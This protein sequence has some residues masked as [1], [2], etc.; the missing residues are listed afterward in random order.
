MVIKLMKLMKLIEINQREL[1]ELRLKQLKKQKYI[2]PICKRNIVKPVLDH[3]H[4]KRIKGTGLCRG[5]LCATCNV[6][7]GKI[8]NN[9]IR[10]CIS[11]DILPFVL[12]NLADYIENP[13][14]E[15]KYIHPSERTFKKLGKR[16]YNKI[17][18][19]YFNIFPNRKKVPK[20]PRSGKLTKQFEELLDLTNKYLK[21]K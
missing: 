5:V 2:C 16:D 15:Q 21:R 14:M 13:P 10:Y 12:R 11:Q 8:E 7:L 9:S 4:T 3:H 1:K 17:K 18:K 6:F 19:H 20:Y